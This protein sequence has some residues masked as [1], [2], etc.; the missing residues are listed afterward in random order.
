M[1]DSLALIV[2]SCDAYEDLWP[3]FFRLRDLFWPDCCYK[4]YLVTES[5]A[6]TYKGVEVINTGT[7]LN[8]TGRLAYA[9]NVINAPLVGLFLDDFYISGRIDSNQIQQLQ[10]LMCEKH[11][12]HINMSDVFYSLIKMPDPHIYYADHLFHIP[13]HKKYG[14]STAAAIWNRIYLRNLIG[15]KDCSAWQFEMDMCDIASS[16]EGYRGIALCDDRMPFKVTTVPVVI[17]GKYFPKSFAHF[18]KLGYVLQRGDRQVMSFKETW[19]YIIKEKT[20]A[21]LRPYPAIA[22]RL[23]LL[24]Q[25][26]CNVK[27]FTQQ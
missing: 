3:D 4:W 10:K 12:D 2:L 14:L 20:R 27:F 8:W 9:L 1:N 24:L 16:S 7:D 15:T 17:Q 23:K 21:L 18:R 11:I 22:G 19:S 6:F 25:K 26:F 5:K 13:S